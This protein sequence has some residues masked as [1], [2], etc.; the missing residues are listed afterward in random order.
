MTLEELKKRA[1]KR[2]SGE[3]QCNLLDESLTCFG[4][5]T[6]GFHVVRNG[7]I[8]EVYYC[9]R[10]H[11]SLVKTFQTEEGLCDFIYR[12]YRQDHCSW[13]EILLLLG[14]IVA[15]LAVFFLVTPIY[16]IVLGIVIGVLTLIL[17]LILLK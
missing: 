9:E 12:E 8:W 16:K 6:E 4:S 17:L 2:H 15:V 11:G 5:Y 14:S 3:I 7:E 10:G 13:W 1:G